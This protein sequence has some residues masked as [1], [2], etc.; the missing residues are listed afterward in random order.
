MPEPLRFLPDA[1]ALL[2]RS[3][4]AIVAFG[5]WVDAGSGG[6]G[7]GRGGTGGGGTTGGGTTIHGAGAATVGT[8]TARTTG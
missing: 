4:R 7:G 3:P 2:L 1:E 8:G 6:T 5:G